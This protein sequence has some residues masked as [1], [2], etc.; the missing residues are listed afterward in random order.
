M[1]D[2]HVS[3][4]YHATL[5]WRVISRSPEGFGLSLLSFPEKN[6]VNSLKE[7]LGEAGRIWE[8]TIRPVI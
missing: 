3:A 4:I 6:A 7:I 1:N 2:G 8:E 5:L